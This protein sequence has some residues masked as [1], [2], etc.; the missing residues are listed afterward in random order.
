[1]GAGVDLIDRLDVG[2]IRAARD[3]VAGDCRHVAQLARDQLRRRRRG[4]RADRR[5][6]EIVKRAHL[7]FRRLY[8]DIIGNAVCRICPKIGQHLL[9]R[10]EARAQIGADVARGDPELQ[11]PRTVDL[12]IQVRGIDFLLQMRVGDA[13]NGRYATAELLGYP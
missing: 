13:R 12:H 8:G 3:R 6:G 5:I 7:I 9:G 2:L 10:A 11:S 1:M 4:P